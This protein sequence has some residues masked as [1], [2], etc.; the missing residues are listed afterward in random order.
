M[1][2]S[3]GKH[4][5]LFQR[6]CC[7]IHLLVTCQHQLVQLWEFYISPQRS[8][9]TP[10]TALFHIKQ[11]EKQ[12]GATIR[13]VLSQAMLEYI[14]IYIIENVRKRCYLLFSSI[15]NYQ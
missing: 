6:R 2:I 4:L 7:K 5:K 14:L 8:W 13:Y 15:I 11:M 12:N 10:V 3:S 9:H 1:R